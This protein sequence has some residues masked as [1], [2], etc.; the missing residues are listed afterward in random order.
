MR[1]LLALVAVLLLSFTT[2]ASAAINFASLEWGLTANQAHAIMLKKG[3]KFVAVVPVDGARDV[4]YT[5]IVG[6]ASANIFL[7]YN[8]DDEL[9]CVT[10]ITEEVSSPMQ[11]F[12]ALSSTLT[13]KYGAPESEQDKRSAQFEDITSVTQLSQGIRLG[14]VYMETYWSDDEAGVAIETLKGGNIRLDYYGPLWQDEYDRREAG[15][16][17]DL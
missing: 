1:K 3:Y 17:N 11:L 7:K 4:R 16:T 9:A 10:V 8:S 15:K 13:E 14:E 2:Y 6:T 5:G 12:N